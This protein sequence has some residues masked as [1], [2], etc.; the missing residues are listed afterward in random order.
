MSAREKIVNELKAVFWTSL[1]FLCWFG[2][3]MLIKQLLLHEYK[4]EFYGASIVILGAMVSAKAVLILEKAPI[5]HKSKT[6]LSVILKR[7]LV[8]LLG[9]FLILVFEKA[10]EARHEY[11]GFINAL[12]S[13]TKE[14]NMYHIWANILVVFGALLFYNLW[15]V[16]K[17]HLGKGG[18]KEILLGPSPADIEE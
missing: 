13:L 1:Y 8:Y 3:L 17:N 12:K 6:A 10:Y 11:G 5:F 7:S 15:T 2:G 18:L 9:V 14:A 4:I 16:I